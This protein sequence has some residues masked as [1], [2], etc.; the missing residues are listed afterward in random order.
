[1]S[2]AEALGWVVVTLLGAGCFVGALV[3]FILE[4]R[5]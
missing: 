3:Y 2:L 4:A 1:M 5:R